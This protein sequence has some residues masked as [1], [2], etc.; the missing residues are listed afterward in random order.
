MYPVFAGDMMH[1]KGPLNYREI[2]LKDNNTTIRYFLNI[3]NWG[4]LKYPWYN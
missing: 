2:K 4:K 1:P 3:K